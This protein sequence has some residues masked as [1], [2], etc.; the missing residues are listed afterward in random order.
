MRHLSKVW[1]KMTKEQQAKYKMMSDRDRSRFE[2]QRR[3][4]KLQHD[5]EKQA[6]RVD[7]PREVLNPE[8]MPSFTL[9]E[10]V[11]VKPP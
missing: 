6:A 8:S 4:N 9:A 10:P 11:A 7:T 2:E 5:Y 3:I 1:K